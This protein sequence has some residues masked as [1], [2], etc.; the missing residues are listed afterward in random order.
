[1]EED[2]KLT[3][4]MNESAS[5]AVHVRSWD[6]RSPRPLEPFLRSADRTPESW[7]RL[8]ESFA[9]LPYLSGLLA[10]LRRESEESSPL[11]WGLLL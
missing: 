7:C 9:T 4:N 8:P 6:P 2:E 11:V 3:F 5:A 10:R 1:M